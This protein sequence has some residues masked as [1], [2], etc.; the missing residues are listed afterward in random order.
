MSVHIAPL[1]S[2]MRKIRF[3]PQPAPIFPDG[4]PTRAD[5][6]LAI[7]L[8][9]ELDDDSL[10]WYGGAAAVDQLRSRLHP[11]RAHGG[12]GGQKCL[13]KCDG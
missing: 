5:I 7:A 13:D 10:R 6:R 3:R 4:A 8:F 11:P 12:W 2:W 9:N 1:E